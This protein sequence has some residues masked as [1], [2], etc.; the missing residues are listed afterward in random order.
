MSVYTGVVKW[1][2]SKQQSFGFITRDDGGEVFVHFRA[3]TDEGQADPRYKTLVPGQ[4]VVFEIGPGHFCDGTQALN[5]KVVIDGYNG[6]RE[7]DAK[8]AG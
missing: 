6:E 4:R 2:A 1:F 7:Q 8:P 5:V 3:L